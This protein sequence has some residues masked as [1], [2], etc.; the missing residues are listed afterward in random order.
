MPP[1]GENDAQPDSSSAEIG[2]RRRTTCVEKC[3][4]IARSYRSGRD[5]GAT[6]SLRWRQVSGDGVDGRELA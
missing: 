3:V 6:P 5:D 1:S 2:S 4:R